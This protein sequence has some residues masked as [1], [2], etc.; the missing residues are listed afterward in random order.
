LVYYR[1]HDNARL[2]EILHC[3]HGLRKLPRF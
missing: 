3:R 1:V 2:V